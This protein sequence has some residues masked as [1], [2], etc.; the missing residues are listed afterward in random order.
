[1]EIDFDIAY[2]GGKGF[3]TLEYFVDSRT[4]IWKLDSSKQITFC[5]DTIE[6]KKE[7]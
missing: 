5:P 4:L 3:A 7:K 2:S 1:M 6:L